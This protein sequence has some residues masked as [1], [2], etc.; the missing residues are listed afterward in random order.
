MPWGPSGWVGG[1][2]RD[3][4]WAGE[5]RQPSMVLCPVLPAPQHGQA[6]GRLLCPFTSTASTP[7][8]TQTPYRDLCLL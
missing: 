8:A 4:Q 3:R 6:A 7:S 5:G 1:A 2:G